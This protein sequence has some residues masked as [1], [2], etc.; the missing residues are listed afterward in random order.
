MI[1]AWHKKD[2]LLFKA[3][4]FRFHRRLCTSRTSES[5]LI[6]CYTLSLNAAHVSSVATRFI[7]Y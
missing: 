6:Y 7:K 4:H 1:V 5:E 2:P 3:F